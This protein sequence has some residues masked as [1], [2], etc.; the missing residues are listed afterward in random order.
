MV[1]SL[2]SNEPEWLREVRAGA[3]GRF[4]AIATPTERSEGW[5][6]LSLKGVELVPPRPE[7]S[8]FKITVSSADR[9]RGVVAKSLTEA[10]VSHESIV[11]EALLQARGGRTVGKYSALAEA[12]WQSGAFIYVPDGVETTEPI[13]VEIEAGTYPRVVIAIGKN[14]RAA[15]TQAQREQD[16]FSPGISDIALADGAHL[17]YAHVQQCG[18]KT[19]VFSHQHARIAAAAKLVT[20]N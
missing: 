5:R 18:P 3:F 17:T 4:E 8:T 9:A 16:P 14:A 11:Q 10:L 19:T 1:A 12:A 20:F 15:V 6:R 13:V 2:S 7:V